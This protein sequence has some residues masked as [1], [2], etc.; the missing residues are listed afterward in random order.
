MSLF[1]CLKPS[2]PTFFLNLY[3]YIHFETCTCFFSST[4]FSLTRSPLRR[5]G[6]ADIH[7]YIYMHAHIHTHIHVYIYI[8]IKVYSCVYRCLHATNARFYS[9]YQRPGYKLCDDP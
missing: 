6:S 5:P 4:S 3:I 7:I 2:W 9:T 1:Q 8:Y